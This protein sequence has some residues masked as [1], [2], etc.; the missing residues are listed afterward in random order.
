MIERQNLNGGVR[1]T[2]QEAIH[3][4][5]DMRVLFKVILLMKGGSSKW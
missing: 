3:T 1:E 2:Y 5:L 4:V